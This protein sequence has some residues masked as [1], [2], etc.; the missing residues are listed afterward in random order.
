MTS[1][2]SPGDFSKLFRQFDLNGD[3][4][5][6]ASEVEHVL[7][8]MA[9]VISPSDGDALRER[10]S[11]AG[12][13]TLS[14]FNHWAEG[15]GGLA[16]ARQ[17]EAIFELIDRDGNGRLCAAE[18]AELLIAL[19]PLCPGLPPVAELLAGLDRDGDGLISPEELLSLLDSHPAVELS[20]ADLKQLRKTLSQYVGAATHPRVALLEVDCDLGAGTR[21]AGSG[22]DLL[23]QAADHQLHLRQISDRL[24]EE[25]QGQSRPEARSADPGSGIATP[26]ARHIE[27]IAEV[28]RQ[29]TD[30]VSSSLKR[31]L[32]PIVIAGDHST[33]A[34]TLAGIRRA[35]PD[36]RLGV[37]WI[38]A[39]ADIHSPFTTPS[40]NMHGMPL[41]IAAGHDNHSQAINQ[42][43]A[44]TC[45][46]WK[47]L[48]NLSGTGRPSIDLADLIYVAV[49]DTESAEQFT[50]RSFGIPVLSTDEVR[51][52]GGER[53][54]GRCLE[55]LA[56][57]DLIYVSF[58][59]DAM[60][61]T[62]CKGTGTPVPGGLWVDEC[63]QLLRALLAD[64]RVCCWEICEINPH[65][66]SLNNLAELSLCL[67]QEVLEALDARL[68]DERH[69]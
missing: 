58:D 39:H 28:M 44:T 64:P 48:Q 31:G 24:I 37:V 61:S 30:L 33:A 15:R 34:S 45:L 25:I 14:E 16:L 12:E 8:S 69:S 63:R 26:H 50:I 42:P 54:A 53:A 62:I 11:L 66:D 68:G 60:D 1:T 2:R 3:G 5:I 43:D 21:G 55:H 57:V 6:S 59:M 13:L 9:G 35:H 36:Q 19:S 23:K 46:I 27:A 29:A 41:A 49:R 67:Y 17:V 65:L 56:D 18:L 51:Q 52:L 47:E 40:G 10:L 20:L 38:D 7:L 22:I 32:F 4:W